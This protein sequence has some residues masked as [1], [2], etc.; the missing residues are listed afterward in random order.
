MIRKGTRNDI[1]SIATIYEKLLDNQ[2]QNKVTIGWIRNVYPTQETAIEAL[3]SDEL[4]VL[5]DNHQ[6]VGAARI[7]QI[8]V[9]DYAK[10]R[11]E[12]PVSDNEVMV[13]HTLVIDPECSG[14]GYG[15]QF[16]K[17]YEDYSLQH[18]CHYLRID[19]NAKNKN[20]RALY[21]KLGFK[22]IDIVPCIFNGIPDV[23]LVC[24]EKKI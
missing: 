3:E 16:V 21:K 20:A 1:E 9:P 22:E 10:A 2:D 5:E 11:W 8:Q 13:M 19:T 7:N 15:T 17:F 6:I 18:D 12:Y 14:H 23:Q 4:F 24:L